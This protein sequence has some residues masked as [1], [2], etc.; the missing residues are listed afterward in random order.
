MWEVVTELCRSS[1]PNFAKSTEG[2]YHCLVL[3]TVFTNNTHAVAM[4]M[5]GNV[6]AYEAVERLHIK[7]KNFRD[8]LTEIQAATVKIREKKKV[9]TLN[10]AHYSTGKVSA[11]FT[12]T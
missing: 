11:S 1:M 10:T 9:D 5:T 7:A 12:S 8:Q 2:K 3:F 4:R 6:Y